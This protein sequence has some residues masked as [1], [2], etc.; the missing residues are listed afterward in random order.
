MFTSLSLWGLRIQHSRG[1]IDS[2]V[3]DRPDEYEK[4]YQTALT[5]LHLQKAIKSPKEFENLA[6]IDTTFILNHFLFYIR[7]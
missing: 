6:L 7:I 5:L 4:A 3:R 2:V 1:R